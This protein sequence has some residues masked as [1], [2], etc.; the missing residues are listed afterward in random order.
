MYDFS[1]KGIGSI[2]LYVPGKPIEEVQREYGL[3]HIVK[4][5]SNENP[6]GVSRLALE[7]MKNE[8]EKSYLYPDPTSLPLR[9]RLGNDFSVPPDDI[10]VSN[11]MDNILF[12]IEQAF[13][14]EG[15]EVL[16]CAPSFATYYIGCV[17][18]GGKYV[19]VPLRDSVFDLDAIKAAITDKTKIIFICNP[20]NPTGTIVTKS[21]VEKFMKDIPP[22]VIVVF[23]EAYAEFVSEE[24]YPQGMDY[25]RAGANVIVTRTFS[26]LYGMAGNRVGF[27]IAKPHIM[28]TLKRVA[29]PFP[30]NRIAQAGALAALDDFEFA[31][32][33]RES[34]ANGIVYLTDALT[35]L[36]CTVSPAFGN[37]IWV[38][39]KKSSKELEPKLLSRGIIVRPGHLWD[40]PTHLRVSIGTEE[41]N[42][43]FIKVIKELL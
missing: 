24:S 27:A 42:A 20:N 12:M 10:V 6:L 28:N 8:L 30:V 39:V 34:N 11:G 31:D 14:N 38:D 32:R 2:K 21:E 33:V 4:L 40:Y 16:T 23:D 41:Q 37:F 19:T 43:E 7:A 26:K 13:L 22:H 15:E 9:I 18:M 5:A 35:E 17:I 36:N 1:R 25:V 3:T 29:E